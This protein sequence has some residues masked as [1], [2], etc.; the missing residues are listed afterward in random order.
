MRRESCE[1]KYMLRRGKGTQFRSLFLFLF[2]FFFNLRLVSRFRKL[3][4][5]Y[6]HTH[7]HTYVQIFFFLSRLVSFA[8]F[9]L[10]FDSFS[11]TLNCQ[12][13]FFS[14]RIF[15]HAQR[16]S[17]RLWTRGATKSHTR[18]TKREE[19]LIVRVVRARGNFVRETGEKREKKDG[20]VEPL[21]LLP[22]VGNKSF[23]TYKSNVLFC[24]SSFVFYENRPKQEKK[25]HAMLISN[26]RI[27]LGRKWIVTITV[28]VQFI[29]R[30]RARK[31]IY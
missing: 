7:T 27:S 9:A 1:N 15:H 13:F 2:F 3:Y 4:K 24:A 26:R 14:P 20:N 12:L 18:S 31:S 11:Q 8:R 29:G 22:R 5:W 28:Y 17:S 25:E 19:W 23:K 30:Y 10:F 16:S 6:T 21:L